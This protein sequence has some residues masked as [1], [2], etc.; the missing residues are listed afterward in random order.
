MD[1]MV[2]PTVIHRGADLTD[3]DIEQLAKDAIEISWWCMRSRIKRPQQAE[4][5]KQA[6]LVRLGRRGLAQEV[7]P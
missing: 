5:V 2:K 7:R 1:A 4:Q 6:L 3:A